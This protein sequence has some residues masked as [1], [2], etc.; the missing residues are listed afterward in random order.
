MEGDEVP[1]PP[2]PLPPEPPGNRLLE[3]Q[4]RSMA[5]AIERVATL[6]VMELQMASS[7]RPPARETQSVVEI[8]RAST[9]PCVIKSLNDNTYT[10][11]VGDSIKYHDTD[12]RHFNR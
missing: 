4:M 2:P 11:W 5:E 3:V 7:G 1:P 8:V 12:S 10:G 6:M 9:D